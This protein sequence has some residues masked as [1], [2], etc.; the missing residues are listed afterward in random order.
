MTILNPKH[1]VYV[2]SFDPVTLGHVDIILRGAG[3]FEKLTV[4]IGINPEKMPL[5]S[6]EERL[7]L[8]QD[9]FAD[10]QNVEVKTFSGLTVRFVRECQAKV[11]LRG[12][13][14]LDRHRDRV[15]DVPRQSRP[16]AGVGNRVPHVQRKIH[17]H[18]QH[19]HQANRPDG[20]R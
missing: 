18:F 20:R 6:P 11:M 4:G 2:G 5:F 19:A 14:H 1:A 9:V 12:M 16:C 3:I 8:M 15:H 13:Q 10:H 17:A 7:N